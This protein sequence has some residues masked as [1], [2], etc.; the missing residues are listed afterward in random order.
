MR[1]DRSRADSPQEERSDRSASHVCRI[2]TTRRRVLVP[3]VCP[4]R[5]Y[6]S[7]WGAIGAFARGCQVQG[8]QAASIRHR[9]SIK[10]IKSYPCGKSQRHLNHGFRYAVLDPMAEEKEKNRAKDIVLWIITVALVALAI[11]CYSKPR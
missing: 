2:P 6:P 9:C 5:R 11:Y 3:G 8:L 7:F 10:T 4:G 1:K